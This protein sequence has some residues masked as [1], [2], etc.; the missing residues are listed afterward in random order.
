MAKVYQVNRVPQIGDIYMVD[1]D[2]TGSVQS[3]VRPAIVFQNNTGNAYS[4]NLVVLPLTSR[5][6]KVSMPTHVLIKSVD[7]GLIKDSMV[8]CENPQCISKDKLGRYITTL[9]DDYMKQVAT[10]SIVASSAISFMD[11]DTILKAWKTAI[12]LNAVCEAVTA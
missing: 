5:L 9:S 6:K 2:G 7:S 4:P 11:I 8:L 12:Q 1:F 3:G 10:A